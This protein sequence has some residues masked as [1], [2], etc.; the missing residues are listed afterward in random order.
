MIV[1]DQ[2]VVNAYYAGLSDIFIM[3]EPVG[4][5]ISPLCPGRTVIARAPMRLSRRSPP[6]LSIRPDCMT[7]PSG[8]RVNWDLQTPEGD[9]TEP[10]GWGH[11]MGRGGLQGL[12]A[13]GTFRPYTRYGFPETALSAIAG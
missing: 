10:G 9:W 11:L 5:G 2:R 4:R 3:R 6:S 12:V 13:D 7:K 8:Y 1:P